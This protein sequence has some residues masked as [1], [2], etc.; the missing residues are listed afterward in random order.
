M[1]VLRRSAP[2][3]AQ[4]CVQTVRSFA[5]TLPLYSVASTAVFCVQALGKPS[6]S[7]VP[8]I[9]S[10]IVRAVLNYILVQR[11][12][13]LL[14]AV[15]SGAAG[16]LLLCIGNMMITYRLANSRLDWRN[17]LLKPL[18]AGIGGFLLC[19]FTVLGAVNSQNIF[20]N[21]LMK[22]V[23]FAFGFCI[24]CLFCRAVNYREIISAFHS[25]K[26]A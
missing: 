3:V 2:D 5:L 11:S 22:S 19:G 21:L 16:Y 8:Y 1:A 24:L 17:V 7:V 9:V 4:G 26:M 20:F 15:L 10:G 6:R 18:L 14:G 12:L 23:V 13:L 25:K